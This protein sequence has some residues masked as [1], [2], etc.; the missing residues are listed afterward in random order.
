M[1]A[2][3]KQVRKFIKQIAPIAIAACNQREKKVLPSVCIAQACCESSYGTSEKMRNANA[4]FGIKVGRSK[5][6]FGKCWKDKAYSTKTKECYDGKKYEII[7]D[8]FRAYDTV[9]DAVGDYYDML[10]SCTRYAKCIGVMDAR[11]CITAIKNGGYATSPTYISTI[12]NIINKYNLTRYDSCMR[13]KTIM[14]DHNPFA[15]PTEIITKG[16]KG[17]G[18]KWVQ[19]YLW[20]FGLLT[21]NGQADATQIDGIIG[22]KSEYAISIAQSRLELPTTGIVAKVDRETFKKVC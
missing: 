9:E 12:M 19:W 20:K 7:I 8:M 10:G 2:S 3:A 22:S 5:W 14:I 13:N 4:L 11:Q 6:H 16:S 18:A 17:E 21:K 15:E 1:A